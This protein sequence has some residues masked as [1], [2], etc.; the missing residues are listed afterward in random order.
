MPRYQ[1]KQRLSCDTH[2]MYISY[3]LDLESPSFVY[4]N[5]EKPG[6][7]QSLIPW[8][9][10][11]HRSMSSSLFHLPILTF[12]RIAQAG[13]WGRPSTASLGEL[14]RSDRCRIDKN[15]SAELSVAINSFELEQG[16][17]CML[18][19]SNERFGR[20]GHARGFFLRGKS[21]VEVRV[22]LARAAGA[23]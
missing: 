9:N 7:T 6:S 22:D 15:G 8:S 18:C 16:W 14:D 12:T 4:R 13:R 3:S 1:R 2:A 19:A 17:A 21:M 5:L 23:S 20:F 11:R 10:S